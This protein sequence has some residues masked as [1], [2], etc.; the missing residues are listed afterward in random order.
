ER[1]CRFIPRLPDARNFSGRM[2][3]KLSRMM[4]RMVL[5]RCSKLHSMSN[6]AKRILSLHDLPAE[7][8]LCLSSD[9]GSET[10]LEGRS[11]TA[12][13]H[14]DGIKCLRGQFSCP[15]RALPYDGNSDASLPK[16][17]LIA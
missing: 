8:A 13:P 3:W 6:D 14:H 17:S 10:S 4:P 7:C 12:E 1:S 11:G 15:E 2:T 9:R 5:H 16:S